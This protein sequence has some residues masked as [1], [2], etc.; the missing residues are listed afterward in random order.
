MELKLEYLR[1]LFVNDKLLV[2]MRW[3]LEWTPFRV[4]RVKLTWKNWAEG[5]H[6]WIHLNI[7]CYHLRSENRCEKDS[8]W[9]KNLL[10]IVHVMRHSNKYPSVE[11]KNCALPQP[12]HA[13]LVHCESIRFA[14]PLLLTVRL[15]FINVSR[16]LANIQINVRRPCDGSVCRARIV[17]CNECACDVLCSAL[18][19]IEIAAQNRAHS[20]CARAANDTQ[21]VWHSTTTIAAP[22]WKSTEWSM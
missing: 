3:Q 15:W 5:S 13:F 6:R 1:N 8:I 14:M 22:M 21:N 10:K 19:S 18:H 11:R 17:L 7:S 12:K 2:W 9:K 16:P 20:R 4:K